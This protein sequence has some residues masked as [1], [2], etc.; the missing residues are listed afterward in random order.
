[1]SVT[2]NVPVHVVSQGWPLGPCTSQQVRKTS[3]MS[4]KMLKIHSMSVDI[5]CLMTSWG[6][7]QCLGGQG[8]IHQGLCRS[9]MHWC[10]RL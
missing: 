2:S 8:G 6:M 10:L 5:A 1:M 4:H 9:G 7:Q 3:S